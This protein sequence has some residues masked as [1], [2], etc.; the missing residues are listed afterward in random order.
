MQRRA[1][2]AE[3][4][5]GNILALQ[6]LDLG[7]ELAPLDGE[8]EQCATNV[9]IGGFLRVAIAFQRIGSAVFFGHGF[10]DGARAPAA[11]IARHGQSR[12]ALDQVRR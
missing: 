2:A 1:S 3:N 7:G 8:I 4:R 9:P 5:L 6:A 10:G 12:F 11:P